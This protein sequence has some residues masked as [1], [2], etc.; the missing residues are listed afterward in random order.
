MG[1]YDTVGVPN[2]AEI[3]G[4][5]DGA[6]NGATQS[7]F[8]SRMYMAE[9]SDYN[10]P[11]E[12]LYDFY[13]QAWEGVN[14]GVIQNSNPI[15]PDRIR[16]NRSPVPNE[17]GRVDVSGGIS[18]QGHVLSMLPFYKH[19]CMVPGTEDF[20]KP[21]GAPATE[22]P[23]NAGPGNK[24]VGIRTGAGNEG[25]GRLNVCNQY[26][27]DYA[28][29]PN[30]ASVLPGFQNVAEFNASNGGTERTLGAA[31]LPRGT[32]G[33]DISPARLAF[34]ITGTPA[35]GEARITI[36]GKDQNG[37][38]IE[39][40]LKLPKAEN[41]VVKTRYYYDT[42]GRNSDLDDG[43]I[44]L[45][46]SGDDISGI[47]AIKVQSL[48]EKHV[49]R[50]TIQDSIL[51]GLTLYIVKGGIKHDSSDA[52]GGIP[53]VYVGC[54]VNNATWSF[55][56]TI[57]MDL[58]FIGRNAYTRTTPGKLA[59]FGANFGK[60]HIV[61]DL[62]KGSVTVNKVAKKWEFAS[63]A[64][65]TYLGWEGGIQIREPG[66]TWA[67][68]PATDMSLSINHNLA[69]PERYWFR[70][71]H[72]KPVPSDQMEVSIDATVDYKTAQGLDFLQLQNIDLEA[73]MIAFYRPVGGDESFVRVD[74][75]RV[76]LNAPMDPAVSGSDVLTQSLSLKAS[77]A[78]ANSPDLYKSN[79]VV[80]DVQSPQE[81][82][83]IV[84]HPSS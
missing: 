55:G 73:R 77:V 65:A 2:M 61:P 44:L 5:A 75:G 64:D 33:K 58:D 57:T 46:K 53:N 39:E 82:S 40:V 34:T 45:S 32:G 72:V 31:Q 30:N 1:F 84:Q 11:I 27:Y 42:V 74:M 63:A 54:I 50:Y 35:G 37:I 16:A 43:K 41:K 25:L 12:A 22:A 56:E 52:I 70:R 17:R 83:D 10:A 79:V 66:G 36:K 51:D 76:Q 26:Q 60:E 29:N 81:F 9:Q 19:I 59:D 47:S 62:P 7:G 14:F 18:L 6:L 24:P 49:H 38:V 4:N 20:D 71:W 80:I 78:D 15:V 67:T 3:D 8:G 21:T 13:A 28:S 69:H 23:D 48:N 68:L